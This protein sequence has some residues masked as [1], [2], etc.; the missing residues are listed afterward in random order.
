LV[1]ERRRA[2]ALNAGE[3]TRKTT[4]G[5]RLARAGGPSRRRSTLTLAIQ[6]NRATFDNNAGP[7]QP[8]NITKAHASAAVLHQFEPSF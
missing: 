7:Q 5:T 3:L 4:N 6:R 2:D 1:K 8:V